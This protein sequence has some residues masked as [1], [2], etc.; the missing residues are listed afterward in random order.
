VFHRNDHISLFMPFVNIPV[1]LDDLLQRIA[2]INDRFHLSRLDQ[3]FEHEQVF[4]LV[5]AVGVGVDVEVDAA[6]LERLFALR[7]CQLPT[8]SKTTS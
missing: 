2:S 4:E 3:F 5:A 1:R 7:W 6:R 8:A